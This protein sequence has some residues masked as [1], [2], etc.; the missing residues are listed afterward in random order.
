MIVDK[1]WKLTNTVRVGLDARSS[2]TH[3]QSTFPDNV[4]SYW[5]PCHGVSHYEILTTFLFFWNCFSI[6]PAKMVKSNEKTN[7]REG[8]EGKRGRTVSDDTGGKSLSET[9]KSV[10]GQ[11]VGESSTG[12]VNDKHTEVTERRVLDSITQPNEHKFS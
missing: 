7:T 2:H 1:V 4:C 6:P 5:T 12:A 8:G 9:S 11:Y 10:C 3:R